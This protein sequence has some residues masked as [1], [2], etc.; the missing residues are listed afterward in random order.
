[1]A[2]GWLVREREWWVATNAVITGFVDFAEDAS[3]WYGASIRGDEATIKIG[4]RTNIQDNCVVHCDPNEPME[5][6]SDCTV[7]HGAILHGLKVGDRCLVGMGAILLQRS[8]IGDECLIAAG[9]VVTEGMEVPP[10]SV[11]MG[12]PGKVVRKVTDEEVK[13]FLKSA[14]G[15]ADLA[16]KTCG[17]IHTRPAG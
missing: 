16:M 11:V 3:I 10:R 17:R 15:Y 4:A 13:K 8:V 1:M 14:A 7:G 2:D 6:G 5:I 12:V 9:T